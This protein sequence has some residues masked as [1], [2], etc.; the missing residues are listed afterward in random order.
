MDIRVSGAGGGGRRSLVCVGRLFAR[1]FSH[2]AVDWRRLARS[3][4]EVNSSGGG[5][6]VEDETEEKE[7]Q[8][9]GERFSMRSREFKLQIPR[10]ATHFHF[11][12]STTSS[13]APPLLAILCPLSY[14]Q[15]GCKDFASMHFKGSQE[16][17]ECKE[18]GE[19]RRRSFEVSL[20]ANRMFQR[21][22]HQRRMERL[23][24]PY[25]QV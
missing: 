11:S 5:G 18:A 16:A 10:Q 14:K 7:S 4:D 22:Q 9:C 12:L 13:P 8:G 21:L 2:R 3:G 20:R 15:A 19:V 17:S 24:F 6:K 23:I 1:S 25:K